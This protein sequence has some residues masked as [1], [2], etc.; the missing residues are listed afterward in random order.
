MCLLTFIVKE[1][2]FHHSKAG[3][4]VIRD[5]WNELRVQVCKWIQV[6]QSFI[7]TKWESSL[8]LL[9]IFEIELSCYG[10]G[11]CLFISLPCYRDGTM[12]GVVLFSLIKCTFLH[13]FWLNMNFYIVIFFFTHDM[14][15]LYF[16][17]FHNDGVNLWMW[18]RV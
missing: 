10:D 5:W 16:D 6:N 8:F 17:F 4:K 12:F 18:S 9:L 11:W 1:W 2:S 3:G 13:I 14:F 7:T 15:L